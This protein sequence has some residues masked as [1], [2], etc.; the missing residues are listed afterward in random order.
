MDREEERSPEET[1]HATICG[2]NVQF[3]ITRGSAI[4][5]LSTV[6]S[7]AYDPSFIVLTATSGQPATESSSDL[8]KERGHPD[9]EYG[10]P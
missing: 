1:I 9:T 6:S 4:T 5:A 8:T 2:V 10:N 7:L 3:R